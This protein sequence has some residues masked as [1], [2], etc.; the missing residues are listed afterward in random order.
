MDD[1][2]QY[3]HHQLLQLKRS[4]Q[5]IRDRIMRRELVME[6][7]H[8]L[9]LVECTELLHLICT[10]APTDPSVAQILVSFQDQARSRHPL[11]YEVVRTL[12]EYAQKKGYED[13]Q[14]L[15][16]SFQP[17]Y[18]PEEEERWSGHPQ[19][20][21]VPLGERKFMA[22]K[23]DIHTLEK[24]LH[25]PDPSV[26]FNVLRNPRITEKEVLNIATKRPNTPEVLEEVATS[27]KWFKRYRIK[28]ALAQNPYTPFPIAL[29]TLP[30]LNA[31]TLREIIR[32]SFLHPQLRAAAQQNLNVRTSEGS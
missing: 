19:L 27:K 26:I 4:M 11:P 13:V 16:L 20:E 7:M 25:D 21:G 14:R 10:Q 28:S 9:T 6:R 32:S 15:F 23:L 17:T 8:Q 29:Q 2:T 18:T 5:A 30:F 3:A 31:E 12:Y 24:L 22:R 1:P